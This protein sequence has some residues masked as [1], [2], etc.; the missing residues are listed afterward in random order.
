MFLWPNVTNIKITSLH[1]DQRGRMHGEGQ[2]ATESAVPGRGAMATRTVEEIV[3]YVSNTW[4]YKVARGLKCGGKNGGKK[5]LPCAY[6]MHTTKTLLCHVYSL[7][8]Q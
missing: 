8:T 2:T 1:S 3:N 5:Y 7:Y 6:E 4:L